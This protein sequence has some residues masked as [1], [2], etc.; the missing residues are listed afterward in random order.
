MTGLICTSTVSN[1]SSG[2]PSRVHDVVMA[3][4]DLRAQLQQSYKINLLTRAHPY[5]RHNAQNAR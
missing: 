1:E 2:G 5:R 4:L 3:T